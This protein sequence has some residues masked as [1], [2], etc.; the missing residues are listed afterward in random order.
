MPEEVQLSK[1]ELEA[2]RK[3]QELEEFLSIKDMDGNLIHKTS[4]EELTNVL[5]SILTT[6]KFVKTFDPFNGLVKL[7][8][9]SVS[10]EKRTKAYELVK[11]YA[12]EH[13]D[14]SRLILDAY[15]SKVNTALQLIR[16]EIGK[17]DPINLSTV[18]MVE[19]IKF[20]TEMP[21]ETVNLAS[22]YLMVFANITS[23]A[24]NSEEV[25]KN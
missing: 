21:E 24:F 23:R 1:E 18:D 5:T 11:T 7:T 3:A 8:Y 9:E 14:T 13:K 19:R 10:N 12:D 4:K 20:L 6:G 16:I 15:T 17:S 22:K 2:K 25:L